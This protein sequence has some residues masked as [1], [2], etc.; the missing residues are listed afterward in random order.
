MR[1]AVGI[2]T[3]DQFRHE[4]HEL[5]LRTVSSLQDGDHPF[6]LYVVDNGS[7]DGTSEFVRSIG[8]LAINDAMTT[9]GHGMNV[10]LDILAS[11]G[12]DVAVFS[13]DDIDW[14]P[15]G[16]ERVMRWWSEAP[17]DVLICSGSLEPD[18]PW[19]TPRELV[20]AGGVKALV[21]DTAPG[22][23]WTMRARDWPTIGH[24]P[25]LRG[26]DDVPK[27]REL[28]ERGFRVAQMDAAT[29]IGEDHSTWGNRSQ[30]YAKPLD[31]EAWGL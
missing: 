19:N 17:E 23:T 2:L 18:Y 13:N 9:C 3:H 29:H 1:L 30:P 16:L 8:G 22:G 28:R 15:G 27:C 14:H 21:R 31:R 25:E 6:D 12:A 26:W 20:T 7:D 11:S 24:V 10:T 4:R 5:F